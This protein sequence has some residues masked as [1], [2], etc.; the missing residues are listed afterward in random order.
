MLKKALPV[1]ALRGMRSTARTSKFA[2]DG[3]PFASGRPAV[4]CRLLTPD[5]MLNGSAE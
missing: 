1:P 3:D 5:T 2:V 4:P